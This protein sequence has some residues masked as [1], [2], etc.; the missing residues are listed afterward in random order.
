MGH[1]QRRGLRLNG[2]SQ[3]WDGSAWSSLL[4]QSQKVNHP[5]SGDQQSRRRGENKNQQEIE[6]ITPSGTASEPRMSVARL[7]RPEDIY[8]TAELQSIRFLEVLRGS[9]QIYLRDSSIDSSLRNIWLLPRW[10][11]RP[12]LFKENRRLVSA[13]ANI[14]WLA[15]SINLKE[16]HIDRQYFQCPWVSRILLDVIVT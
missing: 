13:V 15:F 5:T 9:K 6:L 11:D 4:F 2:V 14:D 7:P 12:H 3:G 16:N 8:D 1:V 10:L